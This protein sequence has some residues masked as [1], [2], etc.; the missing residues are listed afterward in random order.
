MHKQNLA[1]NLPRA[2]NKRLNLSPNNSTC[3]YNLRDYRLNCAAELGIILAHVRM[4][5]HKSIPC[6]KIV[7]H[8]VQ[9]KRKY[10]IVSKFSYLDKLRWNSMENSPEIWIFWEFI[11]FIYFLMVKYFFYT[12]RWIFSINIQF[13]WRIWFS[14]LS[15]YSFTY[16]NFNFFPGNLF[17]KMFPILSFRVNEFFLEYQSTLW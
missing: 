8:W 7:P 16:K 1:E 4:K 6:P 9:F 13:H 5:P 14:R 15:Q 11:F 12:I 2:C 10:C 17:K 3:Y